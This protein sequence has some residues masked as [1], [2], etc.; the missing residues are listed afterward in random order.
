MPP[1]LFEYS[2]S[3][4]ELAIQEN[5]NESMDNIG[6]ML[7]KKAWRESA[8]IKT[9]EPI[10][11]GNIISGLSMTIISVKPNLKID[12]RNIVLK[13]REKNRNR[14][15]FLYNTNVKIGNWEKIE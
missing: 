10:V 9:D 1:N 2:F 14:E 12:S 11:I 3:I 5:T 6:K 7:L 15:F 13:A 8:R 4:M